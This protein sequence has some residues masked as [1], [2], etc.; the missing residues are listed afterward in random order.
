[1]NT[2]IKASLHFTE[3]FTLAKQILIVMLLF[4]ISRLEFYLFNSE[5]FADITFS[6]LAFIFYGGLKFDI[7]AITYINILYVFL[8]LIPAP[9]RYNKIYKKILKYLFIIT[10]SIALAANTVD[11]FYFDFILKRTTTDVF[12]FVGEGN[13]LKLLG[14]FFID[15]WYGIILLVIQIILLIFLY[16]RTK[17]TKPEIINKKIYYPAGVIWFV[18]V[19]LL[20]IVAMRGGYSHSTR[21]ISI[22]NAGKYTQKPLEMAIVLNTPFTIIRTINKQPLKRKKYFTEEKLNKIYTPVK[23]INTNKEFKN[24]NV[25]IF[26]IES[27]AKEYTGILNTDLDS[28]TY[29]GYTPFL[30]SLMRV[31]KTFT[32]AYANGRKSIEALP[33]VTASIPSMVTP[34]VLSK[35][36]TNKISGLAYLLNKKGYSTAFFHGAPNGSMGFESFMKLAGYS[37]YYGMTEYNNDDDFDGTWGIWDEEFFKYYADQINKTKQPFLVTLFSLSS[38]HP[39]KIPERYNGKFKKGTLDFHIPIQYTDMALRKFFKR[40]EKMPWFKNTIFIITADHSNKAWHREYKTSLGDFSIPIIFYQPGN[41][42]LKGFD[43][44]VI[45][46]IDILPSLLHLLN[47]DKKFIAFGND[48]FDKNENHFAINYTNNTYQIIKDDLLLQ[49]RDDKTVAVYNYRKDRLLT[50]NIID[51]YPQKQ[52]EMVK[53]IKAFI[54]QYNNRMIDNNLVYE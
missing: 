53:L 1:M 31:S 45:N 29:Q 49:F 51:K 52:R 18:F 20:A 46:Q 43:S 13:I 26:I 7:S 19:L 24:Y 25:V 27:L 9:F 12:M 34:Y 36:S 5:H 3:I 38:H 6:R 33:S 17:I 21:P 48:I 30:D 50:N 40:A 10:N 16:N 28:G 14:L 8:F 22:S 11:F 47:Y 37:K 15:Y 35:Y 23:K 2:K 39:F 41:D 44:T 4:S 54:Q 32:N 42:T